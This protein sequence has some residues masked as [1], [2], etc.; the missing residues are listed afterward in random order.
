M[1][2]NKINISDVASCVFPKGSDCNNHRAANAVWA[3]KDGLAETGLGAC[4]CG[5]HT[6]I[7]RQSVVNF[8]KGERYV[9]L[10][11]D[12]RVMLT[13]SQLFIHGLF[14]WQCHS[15]RGSGRIN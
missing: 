7:L 2:A 13:Y 11:K 6:C 4:S 5:R 15:E 9:I 1:L 3:N 8:F 14:H 10:L 12:F